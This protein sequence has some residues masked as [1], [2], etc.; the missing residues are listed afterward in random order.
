MRT[1]GLPTFKKLYARLP[2]LTLEK[3]DV[4]NIT[5]RNVFPVSSFDGE[6]AIVISTTSWLGGK[7]M[8]LGYAYIVIGTICGFLSICFGLKHYFKPRKL[9]DMKYF[10]WR[11]P[12]P[13]TYETFS[14]QSG[15]NTTTTGTTTSGGGTGAL[16]ISSSQVKG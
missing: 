3:G 4:I 13:L 11:K 2:E 6:K 1:S 16:Q 10:N 5:V 12:T 8:F 15:T 14:T 7:N 9:G